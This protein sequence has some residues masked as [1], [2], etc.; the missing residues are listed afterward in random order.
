MCVWGIEKRDKQE[1]ASRSEPK[2]MLKEE[3]KKAIERKV[4]HIAGSMDMPR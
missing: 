2:K 3:G 1:E 4:L